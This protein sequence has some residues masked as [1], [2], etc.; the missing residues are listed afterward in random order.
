M[1]LVTGAKG[2]TPRQVAA[3]TA[4]IAVTFHWIPGYWWHHTSKL[5]AGLPLEWA[6]GVSMVALG[7]A[8]TVWS[9]SRFGLLP[10]RTWELRRFAVMI[11]GGMLIVSAMAMLL[12]RVPFYGESFAIF[13]CVPLAEE[14]FFRG[15]V[16]SVLSDAFPGAF[17]A[18]RFRCAVATILTAIAFGLWHLGGFQWP[19]DGFI[20]FQVFYTTIA[21]FFFALIRERTGSC[22]AP[23]VVHSAV[24][25]WAVLVPGFWIA[26]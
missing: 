23:W 21:G 14:L 17:S 6:H 16:F 25:A 3:I 8:L 15:F 2:C 7:V 18:G 9:P 1:I 20:F 26:G 13:V 22:W 24:N 12:I 11:G 19:A 4:T 10:R 5:L